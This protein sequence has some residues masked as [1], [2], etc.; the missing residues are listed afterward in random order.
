MH[1]TLDISTGSCLARVVEQIISQY[2]W[3]FQ[4]DASLAWDHLLPPGSLRGR[5]REPSL[6][7][8]SPGQP[9]RVVERRGGKVRTL[10]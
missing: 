7:S 5:E 3:F 4:N 1:D 6:A 10:P 2:P 8:Q 9:S